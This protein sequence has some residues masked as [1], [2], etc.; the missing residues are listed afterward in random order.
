MHRNRGGSWDLAAPDRRTV[1]ESALSALQLAD[2][3][4]DGGLELVEV[5]MPLGL[6]ELVAILLTRSLDVESAVYD[7]DPQNGFALE[8]LIRFDLRA[9]I[10][11][12]TTSLRGFAPTI[13]A[14]LNGDGI[15]DRI[16]S[17]GDAALEVHLGGGVSPLQKR[18]GR[19]ELDTHGS[20]RFGDLDGD[21]LT[22]ALLFARDRPDTPIRILVNLG[23]LPGTQKPTRVVPRD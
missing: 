14:D 1:D 15:P 23:N 9:E 2:V 6:L 18:A 12:E 16:G 8:P 20:I 17:D 11:F 19:Q 13:E 5:R 10:D 21:T 7:S 22:D 4:G 3:D